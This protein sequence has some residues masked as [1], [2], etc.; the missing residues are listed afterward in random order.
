MIESA[1]ETASAGSPSIPV[2]A[3][4]GR[5]VRLS[6]SSVRSSLT[7]DMPAGNGNF[8]CSSLPSAAAARF[9][10]VTRSPGTCA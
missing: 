6:T 3:S 7:G 10:W 8:S 4:C 1:E 9:A 5:Q 2:T